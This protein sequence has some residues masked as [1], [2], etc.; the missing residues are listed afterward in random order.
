MKHLL[1]PKIDLIGMIFGRT[2]LRIG[3]S[4]AKFREQSDFQVRLAVAPPKS[5]ED[6]EKLICE[7]KICSEQKKTPS[8]NRNFLV[9]EISFASFLI[10]FGGATA[11]RTSKSDSASNFAPDTAFLRSVRLK[12]M[13]KRYT[14]RKKPSERSASPNE[15]SRPDASRT[16]PPDPH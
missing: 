11:K 2:H 10:D 16:P 8:K 12:F 15:T 5:A 9:P 13:Q 14:Q 3:L 1:I 4:G 6:G 7:A